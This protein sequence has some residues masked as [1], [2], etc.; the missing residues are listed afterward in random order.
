MV[1]YNVQI[2]G[3]HL[4]IYSSNQDISLNLVYFI[5]VHSVHLFLILLFLTANL[6]SFHSFMSKCCSKFHRVVYTD[7]YLSSLKL[8]RSYEQ[9]HFY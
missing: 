8:E 1:L 6:N 2:Y 9:G 3:I 4:S 5:T 7:N